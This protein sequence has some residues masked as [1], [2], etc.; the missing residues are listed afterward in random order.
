MQ[1]GITV[2]YAI[3]GA[4][5]KKRKATCLASRGKAKKTD[6]KPS[7][8]A[9]KREFD[10]FVRWLPNQPMKP[11]TELPEHEVGKDFIAFGSQ[12]RE[13][14]QELGMKAGHASRVQHV[15]E[16]SE[17]FAELYY[18][19]LLCLVPIKGGARKKVYA[20]KHCK[21]CKSAG[22]LTDTGHDDCPY[23]HA[24]FEA[25]GWRKECVLKGDCK[26]MH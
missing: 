17:T 9:A 20:L 16:N 4:C 18:K 12:M 8:T 6:A 11:P 1:D 24:C 7:T 3:G 19:T 2:N 22:V 14:A 10:K 21:V 25:S 13:K 26:E 5:V 23:C 15:L